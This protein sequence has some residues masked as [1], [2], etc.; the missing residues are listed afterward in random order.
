[1]DLFTQSLSPH[2][3]DPMDCT[4]LCS[5]VPYSTLVVH[6]DQVVDTV[7]VEKPTCAII[8]DEYVCESE[9]EPAVKDDLLLSTPFP[10][11]LQ[12]FH[13]SAISI[14]SCENSFL[15]VAIS[16]HSQNMWDASLSFDCG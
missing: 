5:L 15:D 14:P 1:M 4:M 13:N 12:I 8:Y 6:E 3:V 7:G 16:N 2:S 11:Y 9:E 10:P